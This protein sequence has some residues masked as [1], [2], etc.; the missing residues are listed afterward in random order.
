MPGFPR[1]DRSAAVGATRAAVQSNQ[2]HPACSVPGRGR[3]T[4]VAGQQRGIRNPG[5]HQIACVASREVVLHGPSQQRERYMSK[6]A[7][8]N[9]AARQPRSHC[10]HSLSRLSAVMPAAM[11]H[12]KPAMS[13]T[14]AVSKATVESTVKVTMTTAPSPTAA[15]TAAYSNSEIG[16]NRGSISIGGRRVS[17]A[18]R[19]RVDVIAVRI[20]AGIGRDH[21]RN[22]SANS[23]SKTHLCGG[24]RRN[25]NR[26]TASH[27]GADCHLRYRSHDTFPSVWAQLRRAITS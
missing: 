4:P 11:A 23:H 16:L 5:K 2:G 12:R 14:T 10:A 8:E 7:K 27:K 22:R 20:I 26:S 1:P 18:V 19:I 24:R 6:G 17:G 3:K 15:P 9:A 25:S 21:R 13:E